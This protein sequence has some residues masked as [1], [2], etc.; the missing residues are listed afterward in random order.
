MKQ[1]ETFIKHLLKRE[2]YASNIDIEKTI[3][4]AY[5][6]SIEENGDITY[7]LQP[8]YIKPNINKKIDVFDFTEK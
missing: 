3:L 5:Q 7:Y 8:V 2:G 4:K 1:Y 6:K